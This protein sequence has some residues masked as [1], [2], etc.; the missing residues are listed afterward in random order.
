[1]AEILK[2]SGWILLSAVKFLIAPSSIYVVGH[3]SFWE[4]VIIS[5]SGGWMGVIGFYYFGKIIFRFF[6]WVTLRLG[7]G[8]K[9]PKMRMT[10]MNRIIVSVKNHRLGLIGL[11][12]I[13]PSVISIPIGSML[14]ARYFGQD[15]RTIPV[16]FI[17]VVFW[18]FVL[19]SMV[20]FF[21]VRL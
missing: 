10:K 3:Y 1:M 4:T 16:F 12:L 13:S 2:I 9:K 15:K 14:A 6:E 8:I 17:A 19:T 7:T 21:D 18:A 20:S 5:I 11:A